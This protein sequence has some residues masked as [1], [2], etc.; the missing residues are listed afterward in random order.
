MIK[1]M[2]VPVEFLGNFSS[3]PTY[4]T[5]GSGGADLYAAHSVAIPPNGQRKVQTGIALA[6]PEGTVGMIWPRSS[7]A[8]KHN[9]S[10]MAGVIDSDY[11]DELV[12]VLRNHGQDI[13]V[14]DCGER[15]AQIIIQPYVKGDFH[16]IPMLEKLTDRSGGFGSTG[17]K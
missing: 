3:L 8:V 4:G 5:Q 17:R 11:R 15:I 6:L 12:V 14:L 7:L 1:E 2:F 9:L 13:V 16:Q 10:V